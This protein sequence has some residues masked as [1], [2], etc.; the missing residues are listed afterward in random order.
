MESLS[1]CSECGHTL[2][3]MTFRC[4]GCGKTQSQPILRVLLTV[5]IIG[6]AVWYFAFR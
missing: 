4:P 1:N 5:A 2:G 6:L 3:F